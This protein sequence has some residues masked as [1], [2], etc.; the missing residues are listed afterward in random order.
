MSFVKTVKT[1]VLLSFP[2]KISNLAVPRVAMKS[3]VIKPSVYS[4][5]F[6]PTRSMAEGQKT[7]TV[8]I[9]ELLALAEKMSDPSV[10]ALIIDVREPNEISE[11][12]IIPGGVNIPLGTV[13]AAMELPP[14]EFLSKY[15]K[16]KPDLD[17]KIIVSCRSGKRSTDAYQCLEKLGYTNLLN[18]DGGWLGY[19]KYK[20][21]KC[22]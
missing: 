16:K 8:A 6:L 7:K 13:K 12:G 11:T 3:S 17:T 18:Y 1:I 22:S 10:N 15:G 20:K 14:D 4:S 2:K 5:V 9:E 19:D 21:E